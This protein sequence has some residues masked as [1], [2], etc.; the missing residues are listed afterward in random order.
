MATASKRGWVLMRLSA[1]LALCGIAAAIG[2]G[3]LGHLHPALDSFS[4]FRVHLA[5]MALLASP[6]LL[7]LRFRIESA[8]ALILGAAVIAQT[9]GLPTMPRSGATSAEAAGEDEA[10]GPSYRLLHLNLRYDNRSPGAVLSLIGTLKPDV[11]TLNDVS[12]SWVETLKLTEATYRYRVVCP[13]PS[14]VGG[15][16][17]LSRRPFS[18]AVEASCADRGSFAHARL[19]IG[20]REIDVATLHLAWPWPFEQ[21]WQVARVTDLLGGLRDTAI[22][23]GDLNAVP[24][25]RTARAVAAAA[26]ARILRGI[27]PTWLSFRLP[28]FFRPLIGLP[29]DNVMLKGGVVALS[30]RTHA[31]VGSDHLPVVVDFMLLPQETPATVLQASF[32]E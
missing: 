22:I 23:A 16:A 2:F 10:L 27:G 11:I 26:G 25:S 29:I 21:A 18:E 13:Q 32:G 6:L 19:D 1:L 14:H 31:A 5:A 20:G 12:A 30:A 24:W 3:Y 7:I 9:T 8:G 17:I 28:E 4:H 15:V